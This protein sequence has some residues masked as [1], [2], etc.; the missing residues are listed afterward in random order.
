[1]ENLGK[2]PLERALSKLGV[3]SRSKTRQW[4]SEGRI[5]VNGR[6][7]QDPDFMLVPE[8]SKILVDGTPIV[9]A[10][11]CTIML[12]KPKGYVT[13]KSDEKGRTT[14]YDLL[15][16]H[17]HHL[18]PV[19]RL[20]MAT[21]GLLLMT[22]DTR[23]S[24][25][26]TDPDNEIERMYVVSV[27]GR[28]EPGECKALEE[29]IKDEGELLKA[30][31]IVVRKVSNRESHV[32]VTLTEGKNREV[33]RMFKFIK[34]EVIELKRIAFGTFQLGDLEPGKYKEIAM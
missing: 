15:P 8:E 31:N 23:L 6:V 12:N 13:T 20:D 28:L 9:K 10:A 19:G 2:V 33:R 34:H 4:I 24:A 21:T 11:Q 17:L 18:H 30:K 32:I 29:G 14:V 26:L 7:I 25:R 5:K 27:E 1:M 22:T 3:A 16:M